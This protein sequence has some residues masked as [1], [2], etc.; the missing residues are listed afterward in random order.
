MQASDLLFAPLG[1][2]DLYVAKADLADW[3]DAA[4]LF[5]RGISADSGSSTSPG[6]SVPTVAEALWPIT[7][8]LMGDSPT[9]LPHLG[10]TAYACLGPTGKR[11]PEPLPRHPWLVS[12][13]RPRHQ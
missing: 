13:S 8:S 12:V 2:A 9:G 3:C 6:R 1:G 7:A 5:W 11:S 4:L 10:P